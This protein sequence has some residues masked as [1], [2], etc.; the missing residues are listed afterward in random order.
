MRSVFSYVHHYLLYEGGMRVEQGQILRNIPNDL[1]TGIKLSG[2][3]KLRGDDI[4][5]CHPV[6]LKLERAMSKARHIQLILDR[7]VKPMAFRKHGVESSTHRTAGV[8]C[9]ASPVACAF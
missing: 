6:A 8:H 5:K 7:P 1:N 4:G 3:T 9:W 2:P